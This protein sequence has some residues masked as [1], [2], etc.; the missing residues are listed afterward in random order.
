MFLKKKIAEFTNPYLKQINELKEEIDQ[1]DRIVIGAGSGL[2]TSAGMIYDGA[3]FE[4][5]FFDFKEKYGIQDMYTGGFYNYPDPET[6]WA[7]WSRNICINRYMAAPKNTYQNLLSLV[8]DKD[9]FVI[10]TNVDHQ[11]QLAGFDKKRLFY[12]Q[13]DYGLFQKKSDSEHTYDNYTLVRAMIESQGFKIND[14]NSLSFSKDSIKTE[15]S[16]ILA[17]K[18]RDYVLNLRVDDDFV[19]DH[20][21]YEAAS[22]FNSFIQDCQDQKVLYLELGVGMNTPVIIKYPFWKWTLDNPNA[23]FV[24]I[25]AKQIMYPDQIKDRTLA[26]KDDID[27]VLNTLKYKGR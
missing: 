16:S 2:S 3:R 27:F 23:K 4:Q 26:I 21:W 17:D 10:T 11:F 1:V 14:D 19:E 25:D 12:T 15:I 13:G 9:Y 18:A 22:R 6:Y 5:Y 7:F 8:Q 20:G 24:T